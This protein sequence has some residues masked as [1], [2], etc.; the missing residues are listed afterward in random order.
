M[1][2]T[3]A[4]IGKT[5]F[6]AHSRRSGS[7]SATDALRQNSPFPSAGDAEFSGAVAGV[8]LASYATP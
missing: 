7:R 1:N 3:S 8:T 5:R 2:V 6:P 4:L